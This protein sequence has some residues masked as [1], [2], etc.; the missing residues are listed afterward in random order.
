MSKHRLVWLTIV[1]QDPSPLEAQLSGLDYELEV[2]LLPDP[3]QTVQAVRG[4]DAVVT[5][6]VPL[7]TEVL[8]QAQRLQGI[9]SQGHG[10]DH[11]DI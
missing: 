9:L 4:G 10:V 2:V 3:E 5:V 7:R 6:G 1:D 8:D 11:I